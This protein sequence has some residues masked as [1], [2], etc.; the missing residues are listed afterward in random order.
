MPQVFLR[1]ARTSPRSVALAVAL[2]VA[3][4]LFALSHVPRLLCEAELTGG[5]LTDALFLCIGLHSLWNARPMLIEAPWQQ[6][7]LVWWALTT[8][9]ITGWW[10]GRPGR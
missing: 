10:L 3:L 6:F 8:L 2:L 1:V 5:D 7:E 4:A 9:L